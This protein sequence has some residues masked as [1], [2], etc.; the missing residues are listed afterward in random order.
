MSPAL[1]A[2]IATLLASGSLSLWRRDAG[3][4]PQLQGEVG[5]GY[6]V[7]LSCAPLPCAAAPSGGGCLCRARCPR[8]RRRHALLHA[9]GAGPSVPSARRLRRPLSS[10]EDETAHAPKGESHRLLRLASE[11]REPCARAQSGLRRPRVRRRPH[12][13]LTWSPRRSTSLAPRTTRNAPLTRCGTTPLFICLCLF[14]CDDSREETPSAPHAARS[15]PLR[16]CGTP[17]S[18]RAVTIT[19][20][21]LSCPLLVVLCPWQK[22]KER[23]SPLLFC[24]FVFVAVRSLLPSLPSVWCCALLSVAHLRVSA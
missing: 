16:K 20:E 9:S 24:R 1:D 12:A 23:K 19:R 3:T 13:P 21:H 18:T 7:R 10:P 2:P 11:A 17:C 15:A 5:S 4:A 6:K 8:A 22:L 14:R